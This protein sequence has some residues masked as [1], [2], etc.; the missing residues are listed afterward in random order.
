MSKKIFVCLKQVPD[1]ETRFKI[2]DPDTKFDTSTIK[3]IVNPY[4]E[5]A[6]EE[7]LKLKA[8]FPD[9]STIAL[10]GGPKSRVG[11]ALRT[12]LA[13]GIDEA[14]LLHFE[15]DW[16]SAFTLAKAFAQVIR[17]E[18]DPLVILTGKMAID[19]H[20]SL[21]GPMLAAA[22]EMPFVS[23]VSSASWNSDHGILGRELEGGVREKVR[24]SL[25]AV[26]TCN[27]GLNTPRYP[28]LPGI[29]KAKKKTIK[30]VDISAQINVPE[31]LELNRLTYPP[32]RPAGKIL[33]GS[34]DAQVTELVT[35]LRNE[36]KVL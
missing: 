4:D 27:K 36:A 26:V 19:D 28:S 3:W 16:P 11:E 18:G 8:Q 6:I 14:I 20:S 24:V 12:A 34:I 30:E 31:G 5:F 35:L 33:S 13:M 9:C 21:F 15:K 2:S 1:T 32:E 17:S 23:L 22:L 25:P 10:S 29:M 7:A